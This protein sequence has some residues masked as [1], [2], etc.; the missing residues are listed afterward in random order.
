[1]RFGLPRNDAFF[2]G[3]LKKIRFSNN[4]Y[5]HVILY[6]PTHRNQGKIQIQVKELFDFEKLNEFLTKNKILF[7]IK[8]HFYHN[9]ERTNLTGYQNIIDLTGQ[10]YDTQELLYN[11]DILVTDYSG[12][13]MDYLLL[14]RPIIF[15]SYELVDYLKNDREM[16]YKYEDIAPGDISRNFEELYNTLKQGVEGGFAVSRNHP[17]VKNMFFAKEN[18]RI[19]SEYY[20]RFMKIHSN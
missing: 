6:L 20:Y 7:V 19:V 17:R 13:Y 2:D 14:N 9:N 18:H 4:D 1:M 5:K 10:N 3:S 11:S 15:Y 16:Y 12:C 8:K